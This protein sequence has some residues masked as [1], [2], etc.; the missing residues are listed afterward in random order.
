[1]LVD[2]VHFLRDQGQQMLRLGTANFPGRVEQV[3]QGADARQP[4]GGNVVGVG[5]DLALLRDGKGT[6]SGGE[7]DHR[8]KCGPELGAN[9][10]IGKFHDAFPSM[11]LNR[12]LAVAR[13][14]G[15]VG[16]ADGDG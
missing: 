9:F 12:Q 1:M 13:Q 7:H 4:V 5:V 15:A 6:E 8:E 10:E 14:V 16:R 2:D 11:C 3:V